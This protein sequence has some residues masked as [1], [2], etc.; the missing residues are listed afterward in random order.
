MKV[1][2]EE[3]CNYWIQWLYRL[4]IYASCLEVA[5][6]LFFK[7]TFHSNTIVLYVQQYWGVF[8]LESCKEL[9]AFLAITSQNF[10]A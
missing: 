8:Q 10:L 4:F 5:C 9:Q 7:E 2:L 3:Y 1:G 6:L